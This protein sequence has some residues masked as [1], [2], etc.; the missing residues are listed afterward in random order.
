MTTS[1]NSPFDLSDIFREGLAIFRDS[2]SRIL[3]IVLV[4]YVPF[5]FIAALTGVTDQ[6]VG[7]PQAQQ[8]AEQPAE[9]GVV[10]AMILLGILG[11]LFGLIE[12]MAYAVIAEGGRSGIL[13]TWLEALRK[14]GRFLAPCLWANL[15]S[16]LIIFGMTLLLIVPGIVWAVYYSFVTFLV[17]LK[18]RRGG[19]AL[20]ASKALVKGDWWRV[21]GVYFVIGITVTVI[22]YAVTFTVNL[23]GAGLDATIRNSVL[24]YLNKVIQAF[25]I[26]LQAVFFLK[27]DASKK[28]TQPSVPS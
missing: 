2:L 17:V 14:G 13:V 18:G 10:F 3:L 4:L 24:F 25:W 28:M 26:I 5:T 21:F 15:L 23:I 11:F 9:S 1:Q 8:L 19:D 12:S 6:I 22:L 20:A 27:L 7:N 16:G